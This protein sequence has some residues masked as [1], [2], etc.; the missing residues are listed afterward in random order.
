M[1]D[2]SVLAVRVLVLSLYDLGRP[3]LEALELVTQI[4]HAHN[5]EWHAEVVD[6]AVESWPTER[7]ATADVIVLPVPMHTAAR[8]AV[9]ASARVRSEGSGARLACFGLYAHLAGGGLDLAVDASFGPHEV[10]AFLGW[11]AEQPVRVTVPAVRSDR[12]FV[13][14]AMADVT[15]VRYAKLAI[16]D[17]RR[18]AGAVAAS[19]G[20]LHRCTHCPVPVAFDGRIRLST[21]ESVLQAASTQVAAGAEHLSFVDPDFL[22]APSHARRVV[23]ALKLAHPTV[24]FDC[25]VKV[26]HI[27]RHAEIW[28]EFAAGCLFVVSALESVDDEVLRILD[29]GHSA[30]DGERAVEILRS[31]GI[32]I[33]PS[34]LPFT[35]WTTVEGVGEL[36]AFAER[37]DL[38]ASIDPV[39]FSIRLLVPQGSLLATHAAM[40]PYR[41]IYDVARMSYRWVSAHAGVDDLQVRLA[42]IAEDG[43]S[44]GET[45]RQTYARMRAT[46]AETLGPGQ[47]ILSASIGFG[48][49]EARPKMTEPWFC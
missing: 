19:T 15:L 1:A 37:C 47:T 46:V 49:T 16:G 8:M 35:P 43:A 36:F 21:V 22:N 25:T 29:K 7:V 41:G 33:R 12:A 18:V 44:S 9:D 24:T 17:E 31:A 14:S 10:E 34:L 23:R 13:T 28:P 39:Q 20:C 30:A 32:E 11:L 5:G 38:V 48:S 4:G 26:E 45:A 6:L 27:L 2:G 3:P 42:T 40:L